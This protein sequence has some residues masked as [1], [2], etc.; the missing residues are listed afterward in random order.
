MSMRTKEK[1]HLW[2]RRLS[3]LLVLTAGLFRFA[4]WWIYARERE[5]PEFPPPQTAQEELE[6]PVQ[7][8]SLP[9]PNFSPGKADAAFVEVDNASGAEI[10]IPELLQMPLSFSLEGESPVVLIVHTHATEA[11]TMTEDQTYEASGDYRTTDPDHNVL[12][13]GAAL[14]EKLNALG[15][16][17]LHDKT[18]N[19]IPDYNDSYNQ[20]ARVIQNYLEIYP[21]IQMVIDLHRD[22]VTDSA[23]QELALCA[24][25]EGEEAAQ[26]LFVMGTD[27]GTLAH[28]HWRENLAF[29][30]RLQ[31][32]CE[33][34]APGIFRKLSLRRQRY[35]EHFTPCSLLL[36]VG[37]AGNTLEEAL[38]SADFFAQQLATLLHSLNQSHSTDL[39]PR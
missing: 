19:D 27:M 3:F 33:K 12:R 30:L 5:A 26:L 39:E 20:A 16:P 2:F 17:T 38:R 25:L 21:H 32:Q 6:F 8:Y 37:T 1:Q 35:N 23:G 24:E 9:A 7:Y 31:T 4:N 18:L 13:V 34:A 22:A 11:Y 10:H 29:A 15:I 36:E 14:C 28:P